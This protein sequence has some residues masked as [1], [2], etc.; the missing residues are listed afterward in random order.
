[1]DIQPAQA[2][3]GKW[4]IPDVRGWVITIRDLRS[5]DPSSPAFVLSAEVRPQRSRCSDSRELLVRRL[6][7]GSRTFPP[8]SLP[9]SLD[10]RVRVTP[11][12]CSRAWACLG[13]EQWTIQQEAGQY[14]QSPPEWFQA[15]QRQVPVAGALDFSSQPMSVTR[16]RFSSENMELK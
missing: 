4:I 10:G 3:P 9:Q 1:M 7:I 2:G 14:L 5:R 15:L 8:S 13:Q 6:E 11:T 12:R 16:Q